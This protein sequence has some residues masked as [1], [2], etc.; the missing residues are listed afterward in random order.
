MLFPIHTFL[1]R[2]SRQSSM[3]GHHSSHDAK[4]VCTGGLVRS[5]SR[6]HH[7]VRTGFIILP[8]QFT[9]CHGFMPKHYTWNF[10]RTRMN[11]HA[12]QYTAHDTFDTLAL[13]AAS[14]QCVAQ[15]RIRPDVLSECA[16]TTTRILYS[17]RN[18]REEVPVCKL[19]IRF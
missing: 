8:S 3:S 11:R 19:S 2:C 12:C 5:R 16:C 4:G 6:L 9:A 15:K 7:Q 18:A 14:V 10:R 17:F 13:A 1:C